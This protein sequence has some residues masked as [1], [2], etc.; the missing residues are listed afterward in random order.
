MMSER[1]IPLCKIQNSHRFR[2]SL[3]LVHSK[4]V[5]AVGGYRRE[6]AIMLLR[7][8]YVTENAHGQFDFPQRFQDCLPPV[9]APKPKSKANRVLKV[10]SHALSNKSLCKRDA[11]IS[12]V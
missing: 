9:T 6:E 7:R 2:I 12:L 3:R 1:T 8:F 11:D 4:P 10:S 5:V